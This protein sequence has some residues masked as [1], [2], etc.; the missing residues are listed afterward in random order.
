MYISY[1]DWLGIE[2]G[3]KSN[4]DAYIW[5]PST[6]LTEEWTEVYSYVLY[7]NIVLS[8]IDNLNDETSTSTE[9]NEVRGSALF[10][11]SAYF[12]ELAQH[13]SP[14]Y[15]SESAPSDLGIPLKTSPDVGDVTVRSTVQQTYD[16]IIRDLKASIPLL[17]STQTVPTYKTRPSKAAAYA[18]LARIYLVMSDYANAGN[19]ADSSLK[20]YSSLLD[21][22]NSD[23]V[24][25]SSNTPFQ[26]FNDEVIFH[27]T[28]STGNA[29]F[30]LTKGKVD[31]LLYNSYNINDI[32][33]IAFYRKN[34]DGSYRFKGNY[35]G[36]SY[37]VPF[38][39]IATDEVYLIRAE[40]YARQNKVTEALNDLDSLLIK[41]WK[42]GT[43]V[44]VTATNATDALN[45]IL[46]ERRKELCFRPSLRWM[47]LRRLNLDN[48][49]AITLKRILNGQVYEL[50]PNDYRYTFLIPTSVVSMS[51]IKQNPR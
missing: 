6:D 18:L 11:R 3:W 41:R 48:N 49:Y 14:Q 35:N 2:T 45:K 28:S 23:L 51:G 25:T 29:M 8:T 10:Y 27:A 30:T 16:F 24:N 17:P 26:Q 4:Q 43:F 5:Y 31:T 19:Y 38:T 15:S 32:R 22:N 46:E 7:A 40:C 1:N 36:S 9:K 42:I 44:P 50:P 21:Y 13:F 37:S 20:I 33:K 34:T 47:D 12:Y 39:G